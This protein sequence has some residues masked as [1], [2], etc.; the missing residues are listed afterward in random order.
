VSIP[1][2]SLGGLR[3][4]QTLR[5]AAGVGIE[6][7]SGILTRRFDAGF[8]GGSGPETVSDRPVFTGIPV[9]LPEPP[10]IRLEAVRPGNDDL[11]LRWN[12]V[13]GEAYR[14]EVTGDLR[15]P[16]APLQEIPARSD[17]GPATVRMSLGPGARF[18]RVRA[19]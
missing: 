16:F 1:R 7:G 11:E 19:R 14:L 10:P 18:F 4:G 5:V 15:E 6:M 12:G 17:D 13:A 2:S 8:L 3:R 9:I